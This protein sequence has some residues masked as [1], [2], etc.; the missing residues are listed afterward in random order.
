MEGK[1]GP[2]R[3]LWWWAGKVKVTVSFAL[4]LTYFLVLFLI[5]IYDFLINHNIDQR[6]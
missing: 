4:L 3:H 5:F 2:F 6:T 1:E